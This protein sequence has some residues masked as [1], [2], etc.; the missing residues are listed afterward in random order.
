MYLYIKALHIIFIVN[1]FAGLFYMPRLFIYTTEA[2]EK[3]EPARSILLEQ[4]KVMQQR[5][6]FI[7]T[8]PAAII[9]LVF[10][11]WL[12]IESGLLTQPW[13]HIK[14]AFV[15]GLYG[16]HLSLH[17]I[18]LDQQKSIFKYTSKQLRIW[19]EVA[20]IFLFAIV[21]LVVVKTNLSFIWGLLGMIALAVLLLAGIKLYAL[22]R[23]RD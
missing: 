2:N 21:F 6:W 15:L 3:E 17:K 1:W 16:Y 7:I 5:L 8:W 13:M 10:G 19:N 22:F 12:L 20:T 23:S 4:N 14:L 11:I 18:Y 9:T